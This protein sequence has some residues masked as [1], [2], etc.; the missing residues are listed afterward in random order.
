MSFQHIPLDLTNVSSTSNNVRRLLRRYPRGFNTVIAAVDDLQFTS[1]DDVFHAVLFSPAAA[2]QILQSHKRS[3]ARATNFI[4]IGVEDSF[5]DRIK[6]GVDMSTSEANDLR[7]LGDSL[8]SNTN[9]M[10]SNEVIMKARDNNSSRQHV[11]YLTANLYLTAFVRA[12]NREINLNNVGGRRKHS[13]INEVLCLSSTSSYSSS[14]QA[15]ARLINF[16][17]SIAHRRG[18]S[19]QVWGMDSQRNLPSRFSYSH[20]IKPTLPSFHRM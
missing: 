14:G 20:D 12:L 19:G 9:K 15:C 13:T 5:P 1:P 11:A 4:V 16:M 8:L 7:E 17:D 2:I 6:E 18:F 3:V 10:T